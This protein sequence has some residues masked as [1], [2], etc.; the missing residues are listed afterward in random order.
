[1]AVSFI[2]AEDNLFC[3][4]MRIW[5]II[6]DSESSGFQCFHVDEEIFGVKWCRRFPGGNVNQTD[7]NEGI[8][9]YEQI[10][11]RIRVGM[12]CV[13]KKLLQAAVPGKQLHLHIHR[14]T[15]AHGQAKSQGTG[16]VG[17]GCAFF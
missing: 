14:R 16:I 5:Q 10:L 11:I 9:A 12:A 8:R 6:R 13:K 2:A 15:A 7:L 1:M 3:V 17:N 4:C